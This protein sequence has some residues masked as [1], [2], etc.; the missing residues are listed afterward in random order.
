MLVL[1][2]QL[3]VSSLCCLVASAVVTCLVISLTH[4]HSFILSSVFLD[5]F[6]DS[7]HFYNGVIIVNY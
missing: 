6:V 4:P 2:S 7:P 1:G 5:I 3:K